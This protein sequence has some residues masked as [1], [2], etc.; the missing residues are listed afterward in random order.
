L[1]LQQSEELA[2]LGNWDYD[3]Q[4]GRFT[5][6]DGMYRLFN[7]V[8]GTN[9]QPEIYLEYATQAGRPAAE[10]VVNHIR[11]GDRDFEETLEIKVDGQ[12]KLLQLKATVVK[13]P[14]GNVLRVLG[15]DIDVTAVRKA[16]ETIRKLETEQQ[17][18]IFR[19]SLA[20]QEE[21]RRRISESLHNGLGQLLYGI[22]ISMERVTENQAVNQPQIFARNKNYTEQLLKD[23]IAESRRISHELM[24]TMLEDFGLHAAINDVCQ[25]LS[26]A[27]KFKC[28]MRGDIKRLDK[29]MEL[30]IFRM[31]QELMLNSA[32]HSGAT[33][34]T[35]E[36]RINEHDVLI[37]VYDNGSGIISPDDHKKGIGLS[38]I[39][40]KV[41]LLNGQV[42]ID[43]NEG[44]GT[45]VTL[46]MPLTVKK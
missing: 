15:V 5:W 17:L 24:P 22:K 37:R 20:S 16:E 32:K 42:I 26:S 34:G 18:E 12:A 30:A 23:A 3:A 13:N 6:S 2:L 39:R 7:I 43:P 1:L 28:I 46:K 10:R 29:T 14:L 45:R 36:I 44:K 38:S 31:V 35:T 11:K 25:Q 4:I 41:K 21:E 19:V 40:S 33:K 9:I 27:I 8:K